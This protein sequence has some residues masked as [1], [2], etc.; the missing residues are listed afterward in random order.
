VLEDRLLELGHQP[1]QVVGVQLDVRRHPTLLLEPVERGR[2][3]LAVDAEHGLAE[4]LEQPAVGV[5]REPLVAAGLRQALHRRVVQADVE[6]RL[7]HPRHRDHRPGPHAHQQRVVPVAE[8]AV[9]VV[10]E[11][12]QRHRHLHP[13]VARLAPGRQVGP[14]RLGGDRE[15]GRD[16][17]PEIGHLG[18]VRAL[19]AEKLLLV[20]VSLGEGVHVPGHAVPSS[21]LVLTSAVPGARVTSGRL[22]GSI[23]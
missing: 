4:H 9:Q 22:L 12:A 13:E 1:A 10:L 7:H 17:Q 16:G 14:A 2:E 19:P 21:A 23:T 20:L 11:P 18:E 3:D 15:A 8:P 5:P 6:N